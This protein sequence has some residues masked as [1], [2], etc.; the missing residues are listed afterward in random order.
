MQVR[1]KVEKSRN[2]V[3]FQWFE[4]RLHYTTLHYTTLHYTTVRYSYSYNYAT[5]HNT[6]TTTKV[7]QQQQHHTKLP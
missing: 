6:K 3:F 4:A 7:Q 5:L 2:A 1:E